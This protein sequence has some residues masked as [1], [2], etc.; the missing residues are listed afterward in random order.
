MI[1]PAVTPGPAMVIRGSSADLYCKV[2]G[3]SVSVNLTWYHNGTRVT[4]S[5]TNVTMETGK[6]FSLTVQ[7][8]ESG[9]YE[10]RTVSQGVIFCKKY[11]QCC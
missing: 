5:Q 8:E 11:D 3:A 2:E 10:C 4:D 7:A 1:S 9:V 6:E